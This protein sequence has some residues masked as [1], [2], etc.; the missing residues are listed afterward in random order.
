MRL[1][2]VQTLKLR[3]FFGDGNIPPY[4]ILS[5]TWSDEEVSYQDWLYRD[6]A[7]IKTWK[8][9]KKIM[10]ACALSKQLGFDFMWCDTNCIN[11]ESSAE[12]SEAINSMFAYYRNSGLCLA[13][14]EDVRKSNRLRYR[15]FAQSRW[16][17]RGWT[18]QELLAPDDVRFYDID[19]AEMGS[20]T[21]LVASLTSITGIHPQYLMNPDSVQRATVS[22]RMSWAAKRTTTRIED[23]AYCLLG[24]FDVNMPLLYGERG[25]AFVRLQEE[26][27]R[28]N[29][30]HTIF[31]WLQESNLRTGRA[32][33]SASWQGCLAPSPVLFE[34]GAK[35]TR[36][37]SAPVSLRDF[38]LTNI[39]LRIRLL[40][41]RCVVHD[42]SIALLSARTDNTRTTCL[43]LHG[44]TESVSSRWATLSLKLPDLAEREEIYLAHQRNPDRWM[45]TIET[46]PVT[47]T[48]RVWSKP[49]TEYAVLPMYTDFQTVRTLSFFDVGMRAGRT[50]GPIMLLSRS[51]DDKL[52]TA[53]FAL[54]DTNCTDGLPILHFTLHVCLEQ[55]DHSWKAWWSWRRAE[56]SR[57]GATYAE[58]QL[59]AVSSEGQN[60]EKEMNIS[61][62]SEFV[63]QGEIDG[64][65]IPVRPL[66]VSLKE[67][68]S[69][70]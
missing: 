62:E 20:K 59:E 6:L 29:S 25:R 18:L 39:G 70:V 12:L 27:I 4:S 33:E 57:F 19:W 58:K 69:K 38:T 30:D 48:P 47:M 3:E 68:M 17:T 1:I 42:Y 51:E 56:E 9:Y 26:I 45:K 22:Q 46:I 44:S 64:D 5:H 23:E 55:P 15:P 60:G 24:I 35:Y 13:Y 52:W 40:R 21:Q 31:C 63:I 41:Y 10:H 28:H 11:K 61:Q 66:V 8:G 54:K 34:Y 67:I 16:F 50:V 37:L 49:P 7:T 32:T 14:L 2:D 36:G 65:L 43:V 53:T